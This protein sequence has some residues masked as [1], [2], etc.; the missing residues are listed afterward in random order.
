MV[1]DFRVRTFDL[2]HRKMNYYCS[3]A[4]DLPPRLRRHRV[5]TAEHLPWP[6]ITNIETCSCGIMIGFCFL[7]YPFSGSRHISN[8]V[9]IDS[10]EI[11]I[12]QPNV[13]Q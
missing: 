9:H 7:R 11:Q 13:V 8:F 3:L 5:P 12:R 6:E 1:L 4:T 2:P 10:G